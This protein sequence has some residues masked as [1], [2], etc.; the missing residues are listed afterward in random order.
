MQGVCGG[1]SLP[2]QAC[3]EP[4]QGVLVTEARS[5]TDNPTSWATDY[6]AYVRRAA[7]Q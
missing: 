2:A 5:R 1:G 4:V 6:D 3:E 7:D